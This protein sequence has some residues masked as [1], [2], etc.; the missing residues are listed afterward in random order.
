M[1]NPIKA[2]CA[3][4]GKTMRDGGE[5]VTHGICEPCMTREMQK[6]NAEIRDKCTTLDRMAKREYYGGEW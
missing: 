4:C 6:L 5:P 3:Y 1:V 2:V